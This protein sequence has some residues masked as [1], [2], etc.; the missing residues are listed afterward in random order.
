MKSIHQI[1]RREMLAAVAAVTIVPRHVPGGV[2]ATREN[3]S[4]RCVLGHLGYS[5]SGGGHARR[6]TKMDFHET[7]STD[8]ADA[9]PRLHP[10]SRSNSLRT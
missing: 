10:C 5:D 8:E 6:R 3:S 9:D 7:A 2:K 4:G 1:D